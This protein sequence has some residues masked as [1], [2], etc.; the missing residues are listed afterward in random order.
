MSETP[1]QARVRFRDRVVYQVARCAIGV[2]ARVPERLGYGLAG[3]LG[4]MFFRC[5]KR[6]QRYALRFLKN[7]YPDRDERDLLRL[8]AVA[9]GNLFQVPLDMARLTRLL[10]RGGSLEDIVDYTAAEEALRTAPPCFAVTA[11]LGSWEV[12]AAAMASRVGEA[13]GIA[14]VSKNPLLQ[15][16]I[17]DNRGR[18]GL[19]IHPRRGGFRDLKRAMDRG[20]VGLQVVD[21]NQRLRGVFAPF[22][23]EV[24]SCERAAVSLCLRQ[25]YP[26]IV[27]TALRVDNRFRF[28]LVLLP[29]FVPEVTGDKAKDL[30]E[31]VVQVNR[32]LEELIRMAPEQYLWIHDRYRKQPPPGWR[33]GSDAEE[34]DEA[35]AEARSG[36]GA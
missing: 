30:Y 4:R 16:W 10:A 7:A 12:A 6:R 32:R 14:K 18:A 27:G 29:P 19:H 24:A 31:G 34:G 36:G 15:Q 20:V 9:T 1:S 8:G 21:Q 17:L 2:A 35:E 3:W 23:G 33:P 5:A 25:R 11:H 28:R 26:I 22:F 13:H